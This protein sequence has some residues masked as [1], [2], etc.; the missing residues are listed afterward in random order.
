M[1][2]YMVWMLVLMLAL[3]SAGVALAQDSDASTVT[4]LLVIFMD[5]NA[6]AAGSSISAEYIGQVNNGA[7]EALDPSKILLNGQPLSDDL[8][9]K[10][11]SQEASFEI[12]TD[13]VSE[14]Q[15]FQ[16]YS[17]MQHLGFA[18]VLAFD[19]SHEEASGNDYISV[20]LELGQDL[21]AT[22]GLVFALAGDQSVAAPLSPVKTRAENDHSIGYELDIDGDGT[23]VK[24]EW[25]RDS[26]PLDEAGVLHPLVVSRDNHTLQTIEFFYDNDYTTPIEP[27]FVDLNRD[28]M[29]ELI[30]AGTGHNTYVSVYQWED[31]KFVETDA[32]Y[33]SGD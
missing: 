24:I 5:G 17:G 1:K 2:R 14:G 19:Y 6:F 10:W 15:L 21:P 23:P 18:R 31:D 7:F 26:F 28:G 27:D 20:T 9:S 29:Y 4:P 13:I 33:Y 25:D 30:L 11:S 22:S 8:R 16:L 12:S 3:G 32:R